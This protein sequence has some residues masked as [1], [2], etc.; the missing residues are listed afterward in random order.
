MIS[1][2]RNQECIDKLLDY[3]LYYDCQHVNMSWWFKIYSSINIIVTHYL[4][5][6]TEIQLSINFNQWGNDKE[7][8]GGL[9]TSDIFNR[10]I[11]NAYGHAN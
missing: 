5:Q 7:S 2:P 9:M 4:F 6:D 1:Y 8:A 11:S 10:K 3:C